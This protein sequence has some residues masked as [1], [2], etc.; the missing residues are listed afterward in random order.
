LQT[1]TQ[2]KWS[3]SWF[4]TV[5]RRAHLAALDTKIAEVEAVQ[6]WC[7]DWRRRKDAGRRMRYR[8]KFWMDLG[9]SRLSRELPQL[10]AERAALAAVLDKTRR[11][12]ATTYPSQL[13]DELFSSD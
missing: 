13:L 2:K 11:P 12:D 5:Q 6:E 4:V 3:A 7:S 10:I 1:R 9:L 8:G